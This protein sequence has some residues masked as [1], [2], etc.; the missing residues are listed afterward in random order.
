MSELQGL[1][2]NHPSLSISEPD[3]KQVQ[4]METDLRPSTQINS[5]N[6]DDNENE[7]INNII[8]KINNSSR[9]ME[10]IL[11]KSDDDFVNNTNIKYDDA[12]L[13]SLHLTDIKNN[14]FEIL[15][16]FKK[17]YNLIKDTMNIESTQNTLKDKIEIHTNSIYEYLK[18]NNRI[19]YV[20]ILFIII[21]I[22]L[23]SINI[24]TK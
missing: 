14:I 13:N 15:F 3:I 19:L 16:N 4:H 24:T 21:S 22:I 17:D 12:S 9:Q 23:Y 5:K 10:T 2:L 6:D 11:S 18:Q 7:S 8:S 1:S 20:G